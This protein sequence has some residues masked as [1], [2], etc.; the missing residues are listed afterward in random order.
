[1]STIAPGRSP[2]STLRVTDRAVAFG[3]SSP[4]TTDQNTSTSPSDRAIS[5]VRRVVLLV[6]RAEEP[7]P[8][9]ELLLHQSLRAREL[10]PRH[11]ARDL[12]QPRVRPRVVADDPELGLGPRD[13]RPVGETVADDEERRVRARC[14]QRVEQL[15]RQRP[16]AVVE[17]ER[18]GVR[19]AGAAVDG[20]AAGGGL[21]DGAALLPLQ[22]HMRPAVR[23]RPHARRERERHGHERREQ[24]Q[25]D[26]AHG[27]EPPSP[28]GGRDAQEDSYIR[29]RDLQRQHVRDE[30]LRDVVEAVLRAPRARPGTSRR[31][32]DARRR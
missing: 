10:E 8:P 29:S 7:R 12:G 17:G 20:L 4:E 1:M 11:P 2:A 22:R 16:R 31:A 25:G 19:A 9:A 30:R 23:L 6:R 3:W 26:A 14:A 32:P 21:R 5:S 18:D 27:A 13:V 15:A 28:V 24:E